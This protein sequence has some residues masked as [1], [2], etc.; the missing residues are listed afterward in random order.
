[1]FCAWFRS[2]FPC[3]KVD[4]KGGFSNFIPAVRKRY[5]EFCSDFVVPQL[6]GV[7]YR[8]IEILYLCYSFYTLLGEVEQALETGIEFNLL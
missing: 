3:Q 8:V 4:G 2:I 6:Q 5:D 7:F 1:M